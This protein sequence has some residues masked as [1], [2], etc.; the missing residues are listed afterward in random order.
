[1]KKLAFLI[2]GLCWLL[3]GLGFGFF[4]VRYLAEG[5]GLP[6][7]MAVSSGTVI[8][9]MVQA[10]GLALASGLCSIIGVD[11]FAHGLVPD[12]KDER[13]QPT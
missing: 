4:L 12:R 5:A 13:N 10:A 1:M 9:G 7:F 3:F 8:I 2:A 11:L 6:F